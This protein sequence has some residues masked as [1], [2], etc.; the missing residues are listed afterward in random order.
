MRKRDTITT[1]KHA[2]FIFLIIILLIIIDSILFFQS[3]SDANNLI[4]FFIG[5]TLTYIFMKWILLPNYIIWNRGAKG[6]ESVIKLLKKLKDD[7]FVVHDVKLPGQNGNIDHIV[8]GK[9]GI[10]VIETKSHKGHI[11]CKGDSWIQKKVGRRGTRYESYIGSPSK[12]IKWNATM[13]KEFLK[14][15]FPILSNV[16]IHCIVV[17]TNKTT[18][19]KLYKPTVAVLKPDELINYIKNNQSK[20][21]ISK[22]DFLKLNKIFSEL[23]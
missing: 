10:F 18:T 13:L 7:Y 9:N 23:R 11:S 22:D 17:F 4:Y 15:S 3:F 19:L 12:Q 8:I 5:I 2:N 14:H 16:W 6:E 21:A 1:R 20:I